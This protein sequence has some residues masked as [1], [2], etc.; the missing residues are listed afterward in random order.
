MDTAWTKTH[1]NYFIIDFLEIDCVYLPPH[2][3][4]CKSI[5]FE[6]MINYKLFLLLNL[7]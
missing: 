2:V 5:F 6:I 1:K 4:L 3:F 7:V